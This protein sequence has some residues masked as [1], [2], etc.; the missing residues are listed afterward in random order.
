MRLRKVIKLIKEHKFAMRSK[1]NMSFAA[2]SVILLISSVISVLEYKSMS[3]YMSELISKDVKCISVARKLSDVSTEYN[4]DIL[5]LI[6]DGSLRSM[7]DFDASLFMNKCDSLRDAIAVNSFLPLADSVEY[8]YS[9]YMLTSLELEDVVESDFVDTREWYFERL[10]PKYDRLCSDIDA[11]MAS[12]YADLHRHTKD[13]DSGF[14][15]CIIPGSI[16]VAVALLLVIM[17]LFFINT[18][19]IKPILSIHKGLGS[20]RS[21]NKQYT[22][23]FE[24]DDELKDINDGIKELCDENHQLRKRIGSLRKKQDDVL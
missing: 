22:V 12:L 2:I 1:L 14:Y 4:H 6:G 18:Y 9:A 7:P 21:F 20:Y 19:Y 8:S 11:L 5:A 3:S 16:A 17:L 13:F 24:G 10:Q 23:A 15:R